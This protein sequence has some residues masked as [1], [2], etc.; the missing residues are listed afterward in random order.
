MKLET[1]IDGTEDAETEVNK[2]LE[3]IK[4]AE[5]VTGFIC[6]VMI[7]DERTKTLVAA[8]PRQMMMFAE[9]LLK[10]AVTVD[11]FEE[12]IKGKVTLQ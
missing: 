11:E 8:S 3:E 10:V 12:N 5:D 9:E 7:G 1:R 4:E 2:F 6:C